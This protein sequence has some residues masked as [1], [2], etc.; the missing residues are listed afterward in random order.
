MTGATDR[1]RVNSLTRRVRFVRLEKL[2]RC[3]HQGL[4]SVYGDTDDL[5]LQDALKTLEPA[6]TVALSAVAAHNTSEVQL[7]Q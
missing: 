7:N 3:S 6:L 2:L 1:A 5:T 4:L